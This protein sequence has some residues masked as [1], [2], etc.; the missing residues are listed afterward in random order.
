MESARLR[1]G[2][3]FSRV[4]DEGCS[5]VGRFMVLN[6]LKRE[7]GGL[8]AGFAAGKKLGGAVQRNRLRRRLREVLRS[9]PSECVSADVVLVARRQTGSVPFSKL[10][11]EALLLFERSRLLDRSGEGF[12]R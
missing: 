4:F 6:Y 5:E 3:T 2:S 1:G 12:S 10:R 11:E 8:R 9:L 7:K